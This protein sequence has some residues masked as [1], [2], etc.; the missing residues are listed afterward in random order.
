[1]P[2]A[3][4]PNAVS[5]HKLVQPLFERLHD[6]RLDYLRVWGTL[7]LGLERPHDQ[8]RPSLARESEPSR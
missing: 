1:M 6:R 5:V 3:R 7:G 4:T 8:L 2:A